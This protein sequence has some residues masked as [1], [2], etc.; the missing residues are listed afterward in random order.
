MKSFSTHTYRY[1][2]LVLAILFVTYHLLPVAQ[3]QE[4]QYAEFT[5]R[6]SSKSITVVNVELP[7]QQFKPFNDMINGIDFWIDNAGPAGT[8][9]AKLYHVSDNQLLASKTVSVPTIPDV[10]GGQKFHIAFNS[11]IPIVSTD[12]YKVNISS[13]MPNLRLYY[14][15]LADIQ[16]HDSNYLLDLTVLPA[17][18]GSEEQ[19]FALEFALYEDADVTAP[20]ISAVTATVISSAETQISFHANEPVDHR[21]LFAP[22]G[23]SLTSGT[24]FTGFYTQCNAGFDPCS[25]SIST[26]PET[27][28]DY[29]LV[30]RDEWGNESSVGSTFVSSEDSSGPPPDEDSAPL[31]LNISDA[32]AVSS[33]SDSVTIVWTTNIAANSS[34]L[35]S[36]QGNQG[37]QAVTSIGDNTYE[38]EHLLS[39]GPILNP[40][41]QYFAKLTSFDSSGNSIGYNLTF[42]TP[43]QS[44]I[45]PP[46]GGEET[47][48]SSTTTTST[49]NG[50]GQ[51][52]ATVDTSGTTASVSLEWDT[53]AGG[54]PSDGYRIDIFDS[55]NNLKLS[56]SSDTN[57]INIEGLEPGDYKAVVYSNNGGV[58]EKVGDPIFFSIPGLNKPLST[59]TRL[60][61]LF[62]GA[63]ILIALSLTFTTIRRKRFSSEKKEKTNKEAGLTLLEILIS[64]GILVSGIA[65]VGVFTRDVAD[66]G[67]DYTQRFGTEQEISLT[68][69]EMITEFRSIMQSHEGSYPI[70][71][72][73]SSTLTFYADRQ[74]DGL[75][76]RI[77]YFLDQGTL[78]KGVIAPSGNPLQYN[79]TDEI[80]SDI[81]HNVVTDTS[82][83]FSYY[84]ENFTGSEAPLVFPVTISNIRMV[85]INISAQD[86][87][88]ITPTSFSVRIT[89]RNLRDNL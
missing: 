13:S 26:Q 65:L 76:E 21:V 78:K 44:S 60:Y 29:S 87:K 49:T 75:I 14:S 23:Q 69:N 8:L 17:Y 79:P 88:Q 38:L 10:W 16:Q 43:Q 61:S 59:K 45:P 34:M 83:I 42:T 22:S 48:P 56:L 82:T 54:T 77:R 46:D 74:G 51:I 66:I 71:A 25:V 11:S 80:V 58:H 32:R 70:S 37:L 30:V 62:I 15:S 20:I 6:F 52:T 53:P 24:S 68:V 28:Y 1:T 3:A 73:S 4:V 5:S 12:S 19:N 63:A 85:E 40:A 57:E 64:I 36:V 35:I 27:S 18:L 67:I 47:Q 33:D 2:L 81:V 72:A 41:T 7:S 55:E 31:T 50:G 84:D 9:T 86:I 89:P 39:S